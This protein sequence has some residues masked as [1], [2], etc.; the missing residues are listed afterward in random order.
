MDVEKQKSGLKY[1]AVIC[2]WDACNTLWP[3]VVQFWAAHSD[4]WVLID[5]P[6]V[7][8]IKDRKYW[9]IKVWI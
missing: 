6:D 4:D 3:N 1:R 2:K 7:R 9:N 5:K 8:Q